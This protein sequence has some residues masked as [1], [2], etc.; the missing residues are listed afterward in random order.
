MPT[1][2]WALKHRKPKAG[3][4]VLLLK[5][6]MSACI[7]VCICIPLVLMFLF[8]VVVGN[9]KAFTYDYVFDPSTEQ[10]EVFSTAVS[11][12]LTGLFKGGYGF[13]QRKRTWAWLRHWRSDV[14]RVCFLQVIMPLCSRM[15]RQVQERLSQWEAPTHRRRRMSPRS[16][17][18]P[19][20]C[21]KSFRR[22]KREPTANSCFLSHILRYCV[23]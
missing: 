11:P 7:Y 15:A 20:W 19:E 5:W 13:L 1:L 2:Q 14:T 17:S 3:V 8:Q 6:R 16:A 22:K 18:F 10:E 12:L 4:W 9:D 23:S 21:R